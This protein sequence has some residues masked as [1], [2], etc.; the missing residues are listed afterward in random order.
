MA[1]LCGEVLVVGKGSVGE[2]IDLKRRQIELL[3]K[4]QPA[5]YVSIRAAY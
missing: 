1:E 2:F 5:S 4:R 3:Q